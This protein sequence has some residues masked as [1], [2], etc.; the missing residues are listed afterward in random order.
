M[1]LI[2][3]LAIAGYFLGL[4]G[5]SVIPMM[6]GLILGPIVENNF[7]RSMIVYDNDL[8][9]FFKEPISCAILI[10]AVVFTI[11]IVRMNKQ[12]EGRAAKQ[13]E[14]MSDE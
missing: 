1:I 13:A 5:F 12:I 9:I 10:F 4:L 11:L 7:S 6:L 14:K 2:V 8:L 3:P